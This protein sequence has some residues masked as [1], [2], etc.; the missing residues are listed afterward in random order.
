MVCVKK[1]MCDFAVVDRGSRG[2]GKRASRLSPPTC[3]RMG[4][5]GGAGHLLPRYN[6]WIAE[7]HNG[8]LPVAAYMANYMPAQCH[9]DK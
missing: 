5:Q 9:C 4:R 3:R 7:E 6:E 8:P 1:V 2:A